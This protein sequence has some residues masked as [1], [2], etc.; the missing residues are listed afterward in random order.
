MIPTILLLVYT[1]FHTL[2]VNIVIQKVN[3]VM[4]GGLQRQASLF[5]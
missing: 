3:L 2:I 1:N 4:V 5:L